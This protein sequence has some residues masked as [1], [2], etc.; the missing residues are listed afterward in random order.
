MKTSTFLPF[1]GD[2]P[3]KRRRHWKRQILRAHP[4]LNPAW[5][6]AR[7]EMGFCLASGDFRVGTGQRFMLGADGKFQPVTE[8]Q[9]SE[10]N[11]AWR[12]A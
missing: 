4:R 12:D 2:I 1:P 7:Y 10:P 6:D 8:V 3:R 9:I 11:P 5:L